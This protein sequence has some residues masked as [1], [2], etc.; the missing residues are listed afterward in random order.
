MATWICR[1]KNRGPT[2]Q[3][4]FIYI[5][6]LFLYIFRVLQKLFAPTYAIIKIMSLLSLKG[7]TALIT[8]ATSGIGQETANALAGE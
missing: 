2:L 6:L 7:K 8:G 1:L 4:R 5:G 3:N